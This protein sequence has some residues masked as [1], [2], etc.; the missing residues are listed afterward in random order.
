MD[1]AASVAVGL[2]LAGLVYATYNQALPPIVDQR[3]APPGEPESTQAE[4]TAR[5]TAG[6]MVAVVS[7]ITMDPTVFIIGAT[8]V[9]AFSWMY[10]HA[11]HAC[12]PAGSPTSQPSS[13]ELASIEVNAGQVYAGAG[14]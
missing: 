5:W 6:G 14:I 3:N 9:V 7:L 4:K 2:G 8:S 1:T 13:R 10:R 11:N 12:E